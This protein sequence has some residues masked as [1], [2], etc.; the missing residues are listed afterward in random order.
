MPRKAIDY[1]KSLIYKI[2]CND[3]T[4]TDCYVGSTTDKIRR[5]K[6]HK[7]RCNNPNDKNYNTYVYQ[8]IREN[9][10]FENWSIIVVEEYS[11]ENKNQ[12]ELQERYHIENLQ[13]TLNKYIP[14]RTP[15][16]YRIQHREK[17]SEYKKEYYE[18]NKNEILEYKKL[19]YE[20]NKEKISKKK[21]KCECGS[22]M[23]YQSLCQHRKTQKHINCLNQINNQTQANENDGT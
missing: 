20:K 18:N 6:C 15:Q 23:T 5:K 10:G 22:E 2:C 16:E 1:S 12:L 7:T 19:Y 8:F 21:I 9:G 3:P 14:T 17:I 11:C 4:I 13:A